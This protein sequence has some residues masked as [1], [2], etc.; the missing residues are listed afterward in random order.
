MPTYPHSGSFLIPEI[1][2]NLSTQI[3]IKVGATT[4][5]AVQSLTIQQNREMHT[6]EEIGT[7]GVI[8]IHPKGA[9]KINLQVQRV[10]FDGL[11]LPE[12]FAR[13]FINIQAQRI[14]FNIEILD[15]SDSVE[16]GDAIVHTLNNCWFK[17]YSPTFTAENFIVREQADIACEYITTM[18]NA[19]SAVQGGKRGVAFDFDTI[20]RNTDVKGIR[21]RFDSAGISATDMINSGLGGRIT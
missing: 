18:R 16:V 2:S 17:S 3:T 21:G 20:E 6:W 7:D 14:P 12:A 5:G 11:R 9:A 10:V 19:I 15:R 4:V 1:H 13:G 8:E